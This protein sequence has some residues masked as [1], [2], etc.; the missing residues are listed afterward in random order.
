MHVL[1]RLPHGCCAFCPVFATF[2]QGLPR[3]SR[4]A[5]VY[6]SRFVAFNHGASR[7][8]M[9]YGRGALRSDT[10]HTVREVVYNKTGAAG[11]S[12]ESEQSTTHY[13]IYNTKKEGQAMPPKKPRTFEGPPSCTTTTTTTTTTTS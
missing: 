10:A 9:V 6:G 12:F 11:A 13:C 4:Q 2:C 7:R 8:L 3:F 5:R 1:S